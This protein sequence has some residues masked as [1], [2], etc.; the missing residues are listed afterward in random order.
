ME[1]WLIDWL[2]AAFDKRGKILYAC[3]PDC[4]KKFHFLYVLDPN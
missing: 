1:L 2:I 3:V 4:Y